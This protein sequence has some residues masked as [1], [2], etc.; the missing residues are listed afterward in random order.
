MIKSFR[1]VFTGRYVTN[2]NVSLLVKKSSSLLDHRLLVFLFRI[3]RFS[4]AA[5]T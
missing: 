5:Y 1:N 4:R 3:E 2:V